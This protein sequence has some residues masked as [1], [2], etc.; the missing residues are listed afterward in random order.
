MHVSAISSAMSYSPGIQTNNRN[1]VVKPNNQYS[2][3]FTSRGPV[4]MDPNGPFKAMAIFAGVIGFATA[5]AWVTSMPDPTP[6][7]MK[8]AVQDC[9]KIEPFN[10]SG[11][12]IDPLD[13]SSKGIAEKTDT[14][15]IA[16]QSCAKLKDAIAAAKDPTNIGASA[17][18]MQNAND[19]DFDI[20]KGADAVRDLTKQAIKLKK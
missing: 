6:A 20:Y 2:P 10:L 12:N 14:I 16:K 15:A 17:F 1:N 3:S 9:D 19:W 11:V 8:Q 18:L 5:M 13:E 7:A 4:P